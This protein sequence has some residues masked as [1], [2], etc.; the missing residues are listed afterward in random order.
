MKYVSMTDKFMSGWGRADGKINK[1]IFVC[2][3]MA[4]ALIVADNAENR[5]DQKYINI[6]EKR[7]YYNKDR[8]Y[9]QI[10]TKTDY[11]SWYVPGFFKN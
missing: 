9:T 7:P 4:E 2:K 8:Y 1:L 11:P 3:D 5:S 10:K 6:C